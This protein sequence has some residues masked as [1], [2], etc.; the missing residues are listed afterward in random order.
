M[1]PRAED[2]VPASHPDRISLGPEF[3]PL[4]YQHWEESTKEVQRS[5]S[6]GTSSAAK[7]SSTPTT[8]RYVETLWR[9]SSSELLSFQCHQWWWELLCKQRRRKKSWRPAFDFL[10]FMWNYPT[11]KKIIWLRKKTFICE[12][13]KTVVSLQFCVCVLFTF[14]FDE[15][16]FVYF[17]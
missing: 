8:S 14:W 3:H 6:P 1:A 2:R 15:K 17:F 9:H 16:N 7:T 13:F 5:W 12:C 10:C 11:R 4:P